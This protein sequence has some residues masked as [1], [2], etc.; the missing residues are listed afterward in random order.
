M[1]FLMFPEKGGLNHITFLV[2]FLLFNTDGSG[3]VSCPV[4][5]SGVGGPVAA[6][7]P[8]GA[9]VEPLYDPLGRV[10]Q[11]STQLLGLGASVV[12]TFWRAT[13]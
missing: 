7:E 9:G 11:E 5:G 4:V 6:D 8:P 2:L 1:L 12:V 13:H 10:A 3:V